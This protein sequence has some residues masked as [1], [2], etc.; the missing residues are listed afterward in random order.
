MRENDAPEV[1]HVCGEH[2]DEGQGIW[3]VRDFVCY[4][5]IQAAHLGDFEE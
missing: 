2:K 3:F 5:C 4:V 1:C